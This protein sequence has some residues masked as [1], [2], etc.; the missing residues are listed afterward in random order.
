[1]DDAHI[2]THMTQIDIVALGDVGTGEGTAALQMLTGLA[3]LHHVT[4]EGTAK[5]YSNRDG[6]IQE[7]NRLVQWYKKHGFEVIG[8]N[9]EDGYDIIY[10]GTTNSLLA[11]MFSFSSPRKKVCFRNMKPS[12]LTLSTRLEFRL[13]S[14]SLPHT[15]RFARRLSLSRKREAFNNLL[16][17]HFQN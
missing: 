13:F 3:D 7:T 17:S 14:L 2:K 15:L 6:H 5:A 10:K 8:G 4:I 9:P 12:A 1:M 16:P 11:N